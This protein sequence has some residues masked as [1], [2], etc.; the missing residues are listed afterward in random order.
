MAK[1]ITNTT[2][3]TS[4]VGVLSQEKALDILNG[5]I[6]KPDVN[7]AEIPSIF[8]GIMDTF[9]AAFAPAPVAEVKKKRRRRAEGAKPLGWPAGIGRH[10]YSTWKE[11]QIACGVT[12]GMSP[13]DYKA[14]KDSNSAPVVVEEVKMEEVEEVEAPKLA[15]KN[16]TIEKNIG[17]EQPKASASK[18][19][20]KEPAAV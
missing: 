20:K 16:K 14:L 10:E 11:A 6:A 7:A 9:N 5:L 1:I 13:W 3:P 2:A 17:A 8:Q 19:K 4:I 12:E 18:T 15:G